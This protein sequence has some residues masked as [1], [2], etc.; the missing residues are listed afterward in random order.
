MV[1]MV[2]MASLEKKGLSELLEDQGNKVVLE[3]QENKEY[4][5][6]KASLANVGLLEI[7]VWTDLKAKRVN[8]VNQASERKETMVHKVNLALRARKVSPV[9]LVS[10]AYLVWKDPLALQERK[11]VVEKMES[12]A[13]QDFQVK[14]VNL[15]LLDNRVHQA[16]LDDKVF[17]VHL[18][19]VELRV[20]EVFLVC[21]QVVNLK[22]KRVLLDSMD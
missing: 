12:Q 9:P 7:L 18:D 16:D 8:K 20:T 14:R 11:V 19:V 15:L 4:P 2:P 13:L 10:Q 5:E 1:R 22:E 21:Q 17:P 6:D 3:R